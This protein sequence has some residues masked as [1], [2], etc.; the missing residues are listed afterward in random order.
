MRQDK[1]KH[2]QFTLDDVPAGVGLPPLRVAWV[3][4]VALSVCVQHAVLSREAMAVLGAYALG[5]LTDVV[6]PPR[7]R[8]ASLLVAGASVLAVTR[9]SPHSV[10]GAG[11]NFGAACT[12]LA[13]VGTQR[14]P[15]LPQIAEAFAGSCDRA[16][17]HWLPQ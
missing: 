10:L 13:F 4:V 1:K 7:S 14:P 5:V 2:N 12:C 9:A 3:A 17:A 15:L 8:T 11:D 6:A 16:L